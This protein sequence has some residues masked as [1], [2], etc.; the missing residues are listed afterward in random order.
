MEFFDL[1]YMC[2]ISVYFKHSFWWVVKC[3][4]YCNC[5]WFCRSGIPVSAQVYL[6]L[7]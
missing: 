1:H 4:N 3:V 5:G 6:R 2:H 7:L